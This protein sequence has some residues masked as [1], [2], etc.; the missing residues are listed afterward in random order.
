MRALPV[1][2]GI[3]PEQS[4]SVEVNTESIGPAQ[5]MLSD[6]SHVSAI[7]KCSGNIGALHSVFHPVRKKQPPKMHILNHIYLRY[8]TL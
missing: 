6:F 5:L 1:K 4:V 8:E 7:P 2:V 3:Y